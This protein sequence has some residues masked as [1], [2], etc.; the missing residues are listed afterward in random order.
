MSLSHGTSYKIVRM[1]ALVDWGDFRRR[2][3]LCTAEMDLGTKR[4]RIDVL[5]HDC[6]SAKPF[7]EED[8][9]W[10]RVTK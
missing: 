10:I 6:D 4:I 2:E 7:D 8:F 1:T 9:F 5:R 3:A